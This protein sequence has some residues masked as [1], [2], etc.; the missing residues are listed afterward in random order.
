MRRGTRC[1][2]VLLEVVAATAIFGLAVGA[3][4]TLI[5]QAQAH[6]R[7]GIDH[8]QA[9]REAS[10]FLEAV[11]L[12]SA[13]DLDQRLGTRRQG[14]WILKVARPR[15]GLYEVTMLSADSVVLLETALHRGTAP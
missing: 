3:S 4:L 12:W 7:A 13:S 5:G 11:A 14:S 10:Q 15:S 9:I 1:G 2:S 6:A 8:E